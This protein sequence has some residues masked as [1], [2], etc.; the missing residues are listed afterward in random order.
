M[1]Y[2]LTLQCGC[3]VYVSVQPRTRIAHTRIIQSRGERCHVRR[4]Q[5]GLRLYLWELL[6]DPGHRTNVQWADVLE[7]REK[8]TSDVVAGTLERALF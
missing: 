6:P 3:S 2:N 5:V 1:S 8:L 7:D 4:H